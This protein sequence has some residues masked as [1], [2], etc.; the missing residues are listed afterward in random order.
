MLATSPL[1]TRKYALSSLCQLVCIENIHVG[2][3]LLTRL[4]GIGGLVYSTNCSHRQRKTMMVRI[5]IR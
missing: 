2:N 5:Y 3:M 4:T 1:I